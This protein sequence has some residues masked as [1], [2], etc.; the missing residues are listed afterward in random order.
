MTTDQRQEYE[1]VGSVFE[2]ASLPLDLQLYLAEF[3]TCSEAAKPLT[4]SWLFH[5][6]FSRAVWYEIC[7]H[8][9]NYSTHSI[10]ES[11]LERYGHLVRVLDIGTILCSIEGLA[12]WLPNVSTIKYGAQYHEPTPVYLEELEKLSGFRN[13][14]RLY[15]YI[16]QLDL[17]MAEKV[18]EWLN[19]YSRSGHIRTVYLCK[20][21]P[22]ETTEIWQYLARDIDD[23][24]RIRT[25]LVLES[26]DLIVEK[27]VVHATATTAVRLIL[28]KRLGTGC[29]GVDSSVMFG[30]WMLSFPWLKCL[31]FTVCCAD[32]AKYDFTGFTP[33]RFPS[34]RELGYRQQDLECCKEHGRPTRQIF[35]HQ[36]PSIMKLSL[37]GT[38]S[39]DD[40]AYILDAVPKL[41]H[42]GYWCDKIGEVTE[43]SGYD[44]GLL[45]I[46]LPLLQRLQIMEQNTVRFS[47][48]DDATGLAGYQNM[49]LHHLE[50]DCLDISDELVQFM[51]QGCPVL[52][53]LELCDCTISQ[54][55]LQR[56]MDISKSTPSSLR[57]YSPAML[58]GNSVGDEIIDFAAAFANLETFYIKNLEKCDRKIVKD[59]YPY[60]SYT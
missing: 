21:L 35:S 33:D 3:F 57:V 19:D 54:D 34:L 51:F 32:K 59:K 1:P 50:L 46:K 30:D 11:A 20:A 44:L 27:S 24:R 16:K 14:Q 2:I 37:L 39:S 23:L 58:Y 60:L 7:A 10:P 18:A 4:A 56:A 49:R 17:S 13:M 28:R 26:K 42:L 43:G 36:W 47:P 40:A 48:S 6:I 12:H 8:H 22:F 38:I 29:F 55:V 31:E 52:R 25:D 53:K 5:D 15:L 45:A 9:F 41:T